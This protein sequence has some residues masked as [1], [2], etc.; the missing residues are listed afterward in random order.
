[1]FESLVT[2]RTH[3]M[4]RLLFCLIILS[5]FSGCVTNKT[6]NEAE[7][8]SKIDNLYKYNTSSDSIP[9]TDLFSTDLKKILDEAN[10]EA[11][12]DA[13][14]IKKSEHPTDKPAMVESFIF[15][16]VPDATNQKIK[17]ISVTGNNAEAIVELEISE[18][19]AGDKTYPAVIWEN[20]IQLVND[21]GWKV[22]DIIFTERSTLKQQLKDFTSETQKGLREMAQ[23]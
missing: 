21:K 13:E 7:I 9:S 11:K 17:K 8:T 6:P 10:N 12:A 18:Y 5:V 2:T 3:I 23:K 22:D 4:K 16:G 15:T 20:T 1:M 14:R 19:K